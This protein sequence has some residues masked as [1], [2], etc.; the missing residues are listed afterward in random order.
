MF[1]YDTHLPI[2]TYLV[3]FV[4][5][6]VDGGNTSSCLQILIPCKSSATH[7]EIKEV[8]HYEEC[9][10]LLILVHKVRVESSDIKLMDVRCLWTVIANMII[11]GNHRL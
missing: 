9:G 1:L 10:E 7:P 2:L 11:G 8:S 3:I 4:L 5:L 6:Q